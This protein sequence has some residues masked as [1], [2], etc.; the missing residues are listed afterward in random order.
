MRIFIA[1]GNP[2]KLRGTRRAI[3]EV[4]PGVHEI[5]A[6]P[7]PHPPR[8]MPEGPQVFAGARGRARWAH[9]KGA[10]LGVGVES[11][12]VPLPE[13]PTGYLITVACVVGD[14]KEGW[15]TS[16]G[17]PY[18][19]GITPDPHGGYVARLTRGRVT[20]ED[21]VYRAVLLALY[22]WLWERE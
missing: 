17:F 12:L 4:L 22:S 14:G 7:F 16:P 15:G 11:G 8:H 20:R 18:R 10:D 21:L 1:S 19:P 9:G 5:K 6:L 2:A 13:P 3:V